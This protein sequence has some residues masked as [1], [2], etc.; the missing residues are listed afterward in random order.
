MCPKWMLIVPD[1]YPI[2]DATKIALETTRRFLEKDQSVR[3][4]G[5]GQMSAD[6]QIS[7]VIYVVFSEKDEI[8]YRS[9]ASQFFPGPDTG[10]KRA[11]TEHSQS[12]PKDV[13]DN[14]DPNGAPDADLVPSSQKTVVDDMP[15]Q[16]KAN[17]PAS[18]GGKTTEETFKETGTEE[19]IL[20]QETKG[21]DFVPTKEQ[22]LAPEKKQ[23][24]NE[25]GD[26]WVKL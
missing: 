21:E 5:H 15:A 23:K 25:E 8:V 26:D 19:V 16:A 7:R 9:L 20:Q 10:S 12:Q 1:G 6:D 22:G 24:D 17:K 3:S 14:D 4:L 2:V 13:H 18:P 11:K